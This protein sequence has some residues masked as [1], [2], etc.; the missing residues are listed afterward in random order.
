MATDKGLLKTE[1]LAKIDYVAEFTGLLGPGNGSRRTCYRTEAHAN[2]DANPSLTFSSTTGAWKCQTCGEKGDLF[3]LYKHIKK[4]AYPEVLRVLY[5][6][7]GLWSEFESYEPTRN[8]KKHPTIKDVDILAR[9]KS[10]HDAL[11]A[12]RDALKVMLLRYGIT[13]DTCSRWAMGWH[14]G[15]L[16]VPI[17][18]AKSR[19]KDT[20]VSKVLPHQMPMVNIRSHDI[21]RKKAYWRNTESGVVHDEQPPEVSI[22]SIISQDYGKFEPVWSGTN[23]KVI[24]IKGFGSTY[25][26]PYEVAETAPAMYLV[27]GELK[28][29][30]LNQLGVPAVTFTT[31]ENA[32]ALDFVPLL[33]GKRIRVLYDPDDA[34][35]H[36]A[37]TTAQALAS[38]GVYVEVAEWPESVTSELPHKGDVTDLLRRCEWNIQALDFLTYVPVEALDVEDDAQRE[39]L[40]LG[41]KQ[42]DWDE[43]PLVPFNELVEPRKLGEW[44]RMGAL[45]SG[46]G[47]TPYAVPR[48][49][50][51][52]CADG[53]LNYRPI[54][55]GCTLPGK[56]FCRKTSFTTEAQLQLA[57]LSKDALDVKLKVELGIPVR[58]QSPKFNNEYTSVEQVNITPTV[59][60]SYSG[61]ER[62]HKA[63]TSESEYRYHPAYLLREERVSIQE[64]ASYEFLGR[65]TPD[66]KN[67]KFTFAVREFRP[68]GNDILSWQP[69]P[70]IWYELKKALGP[71]PM[72]TLIYDMRE[73]VCRNYGQDRMLETI[74]LSYFLPFTFRLGDSY[75]ERIC[76][77]VMIMGDTSVGKST[78]VSSMMRHYGAGKMSNAGSRAT[79]VGLIGGNR[80]DGGSNMSFSWGLIP[81]AHKSYVA[82]DEYHKLGL[83]VVGAITNIVS[84]GVSERLTA[85]G[86]RRTKSWVRMMYLCNPRTNT[87]GVTRPIASYSNP[88]DAVLQVVGTTQDMG[89]LDYIHIQYQSEQEAFFTQRKPDRPLSYTTE[90]AREHIRWAWSRQPDD[91]NIIDVNYLLSRAKEL[92]LRYGHHSLLIPSYLRYK[93]AK[94]AIAFA[95]LTLSTE[96]GKTVDVQHEHIDLAYSWFHDGYAPYIESNIRNAPLLPIKIVAIL[97]S[98]SPTEFKRLRLFTSGDRWSP[99]D[100]I[101]MLGHQ[102]AMEFLDMAQFECRLLTRRGPYFYPIQE[103][104]SELLAGYIVDREKHFTME[105]V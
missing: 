100:I 28:A 52:T 74:L 89:R 71:N 76:P 9:Y 31:G 83:D 72:A 55:S 20:I 81:T 102:R 5:K 3:V 59:D 88:L 57:G 67:N 82:I 40:S 94:F 19:Y 63:G 90:L 10:A 23:G 98:L 35:V 16:S 104:F 29:V 33:F 32:L 49:V 11:M 21:L 47:E 53:K 51:V 64:N 68:L 42:I 93:L 66:P 18:L 36:G 8:G 58:C 79:F 80:Q 27:G 13:K 43:A 86:I 12:N 84:S 96:N 92:S 69:E 41:E 48:V 61:I 75:N 54:C 62:D 25:L 2:G 99:E 95:L 15:R 34:G 97:D 44:V 85:S 73:H 30:L 22:D 46:R 7:Y 70:N 17:W 78:S 60:H 65:I 1:L 101:D 14:Y 103:S 26:Y 4:L 6:R 91:Y 50:E 77:S 105:R 87:H 39:V 37:R 38:Q 45:V 24:S 56:G